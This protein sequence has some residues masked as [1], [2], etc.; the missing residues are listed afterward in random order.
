M[1]ASIL[2]IPQPDIPYK[3][4]P[5][6]QRSRKLHYIIHLQTLN[7]VRRLFELPHNVLYQFLLR[8]RGPIRAG[9]LVCVREVFCFRCTKVDTSHGHIAVALNPSR[10]HL[11]HC[12][13]DI[14]FN[15]PVTS[16]AVLCDFI[17]RSDPLPP[18]QWWFVI[19]QMIQFMS[20]LSTYADQ[21]STSAC[22]FQMQII[23]RSCNNTFSESNR[24]TAS[25]TN[26]SH[27]SDDHHSDVDQF[28]DRF[29][30]LLHLQF[31]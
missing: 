6:K 30:Y 5:L 19:M 9:G 8:G 23:L 10:G 27:Q 14:P 20:H 12:E 7:R 31:N 17:L 28:N 21:M 25:S 11:G 18:I 3:Y 16:L 1:A 22:H 29:N 4:S 15:G 24:S 26:T 13:V 2:Q